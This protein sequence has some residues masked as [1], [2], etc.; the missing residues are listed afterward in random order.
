V[1]EATRMYRLYRDALVAATQHNDSGNDDHYR[2]V[3]GATELHDIAS[4]SFSLT[5]SL[6][7]IA[8][9]ITAKQQQP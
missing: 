1:Q 2:L 4:G 7:L 8:S 3:V 9:S 6:S 5:R